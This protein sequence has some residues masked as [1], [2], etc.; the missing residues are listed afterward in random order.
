MG[1]VLY[2]DWETDEQEQQR[3]LSMLQNGLTITEAPDI[4]YRRCYAPLSDDI[5]ALQRIVADKAIDYIVVDS[6]SGACGDDLT[7]QSVAAK[8]FQSLAGLRVGS[9]LI[10]HTAKSEDR[11]ATAFGSA[12][13]RNYARSLFELRQADGDDTVNLGL[14][15]RK[16]NAAPLQPPIG[17]EF[18]YNGSAA[19]VT[20]KSARDM[21]GLESHLPNGD[22]IWNVLSGGAID[23]QV[24]AEAAG[25][26]QAVTRSTLHRNTGG[27]FVRLSDGRFGR[28]VRK[29]DNGEAL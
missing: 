9:L 28:A 22:R 5:Q 26:S 25:L 18:R 2:L 8:F 23:V 19:Y 16:M 15:H 11:K 14:F 13:W 20:R 6:L 10:T 4:A 1:N 27:R 12:Y 29:L 21:P 3:A 7:L 24:I 17:L